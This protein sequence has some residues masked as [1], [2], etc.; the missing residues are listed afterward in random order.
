MQ[1]LIVFFM[2]MIHV[3]V[4]SEISKRFDTGTLATLYQSVQA[5][6]N[7]PLSTDSITRDDG[8]TFISTYYI[9][10]HWGMPLRIVTEESAD[11]VTHIGLS[12][13][14]PA[15]KNENNQITRFV[16]RLLLEIIVERPEIVSE[17]IGADNISITVNGRPYGSN[18]QKSRM[19]LLDVICTPAS[20]TLEVHSDDLQ[21]KWYAATWKNS[22]NSTVSIRFPSRQ[23]IIEGKD[24]R[25]LDSTVFH[26]L[27]RY[28]P[29]ADTKK[30]VDDALITP[31]D[32]ECYVLRG[33]PYFT[34][35]D[36]S[37]YFI[38]KRGTYHP[39]F[40]RR[41]PRESVAN[42]LL[43]ELPE[44]NHRDVAIRYKDFRDSIHSAT[45]TVNGLH[46]FFEE[47]HDAFIGVEKVTP[48]TMYAVLI[49]VNR[50]FNQMHMVELKVPLSVFPPEN[51]GNI[52]AVFHPNIP[53]DN[54]HSLFGKYTVRQ[55]K[56]YSIV[57]AQSDKGIHAS[58][59]K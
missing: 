15:Q 32:K 25:E 28:V 55:Q 9:S 38:R 3:P 48:D 1:W 21:R 36:N 24:K 44:G 34:S 39:V 16:E 33:T 37:R 4:R 46:T 40:S 51:T 29:V 6:L 42:L 45:I 20:W 50:T 7:N 14:P 17:K 5:L 49:Y 59:A 26:S 13:F 35:L 53:N 54:V 11:R 23:D 12:L 2:L 10:D 31:H 43:G 57:I 47:S 41:Y 8:E 56:K 52:T 19:A 30:T 18:A 22:G 58:P 27:S